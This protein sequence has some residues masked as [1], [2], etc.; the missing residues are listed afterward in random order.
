MD[1]VDIVFSQKSMSKS[2]YFREIVLKVHQTGIHTSA[3]AKS[4]PPGIHFHQSEALLKSQDPWNHNKAW[5]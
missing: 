1:R 2:E 3:S 4:P 5:Y